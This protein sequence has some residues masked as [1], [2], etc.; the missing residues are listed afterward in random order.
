VLSV[1]VPDCVTFARQ[2]P[3]FPG[4]N[5]TLGQFTATPSNCST[6]VAVSRPL[7]SQ[8]VTVTAIWAPGAYSPDAGLIVTVGAPACAPTPLATRLAR[9]R[10]TAT[11][12]LML[13]KV[14]DTDS[15]LDEG[16]AL[17]R[18]R[19]ALL[20][21]APCHSPL[22]RNRFHCNAN[23]FVATTDAPV[24]SLRLG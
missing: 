9:T 8:Y 6:A 4:G 17:E 11:A 13:R 22:S 16:D 3:G 19:S 2:G 18:W 20:K 5:T 21:H 1:T 15:A 14:A 24:N 12:R 7:L 23:R 10:E